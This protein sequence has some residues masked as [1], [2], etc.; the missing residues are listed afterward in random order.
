[1]DLVSIHQAAAWLQ[2]TPHQIRLAAA[3][4]GIEPDGRINGVDVFLETD[5]ER[6][7]FQ[8]AMQRGYTTFP[9]PPITPPMM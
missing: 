7:A 3:A 5:I 8:L 1:M 6:I 9:L 2:A 4:V